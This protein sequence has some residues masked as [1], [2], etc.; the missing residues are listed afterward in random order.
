MIETDNIVAAIFAA[1]MCQQMTQSRPH[2]YID[3]YEVFV[4]LLEERSS[5]RMRKTLRGLEKDE[6]E[7]E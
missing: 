2:D 7:A 1:S 4:R 6:D 5:V 3:H